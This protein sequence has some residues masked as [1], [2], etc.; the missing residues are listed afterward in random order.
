M[1]NW[2]DEVFFLTQVGTLEHWVFSGQIS[3]PET[4]WNYQRDKW[5]HSTQHDG[6]DPSRCSCFFA[7]DLL[8]LHG[9]V[10]ICKLISSRVMEVWKYWLWLWYFP[11]FLKLGTLAWWL[12]KLWM[13]FYEQTIANL[14][15]TI[16][17]CLRHQLDVPCVCTWIRF[18]PSSRATYD[19]FCLLCCL[20]M[21]KPSREVKVIEDL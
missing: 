19:R 20:Y 15:T 12:Y 1:C 8:H 6:P 4:T 21:S 14:P 10:R 2:V 7:P 9:L 18:Y 5:V 11:F 3:S 16:S 17:L 13:F